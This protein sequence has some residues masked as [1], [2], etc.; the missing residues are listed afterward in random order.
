MSTPIVDKNQLLPGP[1]SWYI[2]LMPRAMVHNC[3]RTERVLLR[4]GLTFFLM[5]SILPNSPLDMKYMAVAIAENSVHGIVV[6]DE[7]GHCK[8]ANRAWVEMTGFSAAD[9]KSKPGSRLGASPSSGR[10]AVPHT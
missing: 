3:K 4:A 9:M 6:M 7:S 5:L 8:Y 2:P 10:A 1:S